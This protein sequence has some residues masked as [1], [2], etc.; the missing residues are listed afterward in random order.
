MYKKLI[1]K[2]L[3]NRLI[4][5]EA[6]HNGLA[7][8]EKVQKLGDKVN[9]DAYK[10]V[11]KKM[12]DY[13]KSLT[14]EDKDAIDEPKTNVEGETKDFHDEMEIRNGQEMLKY[15][16]VP[17]EVF[18]KRAEM[19]LVGDS[20]MGN[21]T[22]TGE[23]NGN[24]EEVWGAS[25]GKHTGEEIVKQAKASTKKR[26]DAEY[27]LI[28]LGDD[29]EQSGDKK[30]KGKAR[31]VAV[32]SK[33]NNNKTLKETKMKK[34]LRFKKPF[35]GLGNALQ[36]IPENYRVDSKEFEMTDGNE[37]YDIRWEG[38]LTEGKAI[39]V[40]AQDSNMVNEDIQKM[41]HLMGYKSQDTLGTLK[42]KDRITENND[43]TFR[44]MLD[45]TRTL[46]T[47]SIEDVTEAEEIEGQKAPIDNSVWDDAAP[48]GDNH[49]DHIME[50]NEDCDETIDEMEDIEGQ[51]APV[52]TEEEDDNQLPPT[53]DELHIDPKLTNMKESKKKNLK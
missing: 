27:N 40:K 53:P 7:T 28:Q 34:R 5:E 31:K 23:E 22:Y 12:K 36:L 39:V 21:K 24:T 46:M 35:D 52:V 1:N 42:G 10:N 18:Q 30:T 47:E 16:N 11:A 33:I 15:D 45:K 20:K 4:N 17:N 41:K 49:A 9:K 50:E 32:E 6:K 29:I 14:Q 3:S 51:K 8:T 37:T 43:N 25:G 13:D 38:S 2:H 26:N 48:N 19:A 44:S